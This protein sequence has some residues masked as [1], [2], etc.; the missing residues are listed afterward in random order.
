V[1]EYPEFVAGVVVAGQREL[2][3]AFQRRGVRHCPEAVNKRRLRSYGSRHGGEVRHGATGR[4]VP[5]MMG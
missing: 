3:H 5:V 2:A 4:S 1:F